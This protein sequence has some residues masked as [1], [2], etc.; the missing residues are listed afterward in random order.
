MAPHKRIRILLLT[1]RDS[2]NLGD[3]VIEACDI[4]LLEAVMENLGFARDQYKIISRAAGVVF[5]K[6][7][8]NSDLKGRERARKLV[9]NADIVVFGGA[10]LFNFQYQIFAERTALTVRVAEEFATPVLFSAIGIEGYDEENPKCV[11]LRD[12]LALDCVKAI[13]TRDDFEAL[14]CYARGLSIP[15]AKVADP[16]VFSE[17]VF[18][19]FLASGRKDK[20]GIFVMR[21]NAFTDN[22]IDFDRAAATKLWADLAHDLDARGVDYEF[23]TSGHFG[24]EAFMDYLIRNHGI[25]ASKCV[26][27]MNAP[28]KLAEAISSYK[29]IVS[30]RLHPSIIA[31]SLGI[32]SLG[33][34]WNDKVRHFYESTNQ[35][36]RLIE[37]GTEAAAE[38]A[39]RLSGESLSPLIKDDAYLASVYDFLFQQIKTIL[40]LDANIEPY[41]VAN[42]CDV[43]VPYAG[44]TKEEHEEKLRRKMRRA[45]G[46]YNELFDRQAE[47]Q[48]KK[49]KTPLDRLRN[50]AARF[51][52]DDRTSE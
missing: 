40:A 11:E 38:I 41:P 45:Y 33:I 30:C 31:Y 47:M 51:R 44:T 49:R 17:Q 42:L 46:K 9:A 32:P 1:N 20:V 15:I 39:R 22:G 18:A 28:E 10:P 36:D 4:S 21:S 43:L 25:P 37:P 2:D 52:R 16:A 48:P 27:A 5:R 12:A 35:A 3:Q 23:I 50:A 34:I 7:L 24:D 6:Y 14:E 8:D 13:S 29:A 19:P 26:F